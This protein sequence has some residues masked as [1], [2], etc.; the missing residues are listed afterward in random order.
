MDGSLRVRK[1]STP[2]GFFFAG[3]PFDRGLLAS[4]V[5]DRC[6]FSRVWSLRLRF[7]LGLGVLCEELE[8]DGGVEGLT[9]LSPLVDVVAGRSSMKSL[10]SVRFLTAGC[11]MWRDVLFASGILSS[12]YGL[13]CF[14]C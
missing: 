3:K 11:E 14:H 10:S 8:D 4:F 13:F 2:L 12:V 7:Q 1:P 5:G 6:P 9:S